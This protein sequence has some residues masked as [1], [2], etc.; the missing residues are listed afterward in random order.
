[1]NV[2]AVIMDADAMRR[3]TTR[4]AHEILERY[5][6]TER[7]MLFG[8]KRRGVPL[9]EAIV[10]SIRDIE[11]V[12]IPCA[13]LDV[14]FYRDDLTPVADRPVV[15]PGDIVDVTDKRIVLVDDVIFT[16]RTA[17][18]AMEAVMAMGRPASIALAVLIDRGHRE[19]PIRPDHVGKNVPTSRGEVVEVRMPPY[20]DATEVRL[21]DR[22][23]E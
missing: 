1:M 9:A 23:E 19:L 2:K 8:I 21:C 10:R 16:G 18:A 15:T 22:T 5:S 6:G 11:G 7:L 13:E 4:M 17:R 14:S 3:A 20:D 12:D